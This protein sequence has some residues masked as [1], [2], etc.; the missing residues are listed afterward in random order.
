MKLKESRDFKTLLPT[1]LQWLISFLPLHFPVIPQYLIFHSWYISAVWG[2]GW[3]FFTSTHAHMWVGIVESFSL[4][5]TPFF[6]GLFFWE[7]VLREFCM[8]FKSTGDFR[9]RNFIPQHQ[10]YFFSSIFMCLHSINQIYHS[11]H[12]FN[13]TYIKAKAK[14][15][16]LKLK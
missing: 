7:G 16:L 1:F 9:E 8:P 4:V 6:F 13:V 11:S 3:V 5:C 2:H 10:R 14:Y 15:F 12:C